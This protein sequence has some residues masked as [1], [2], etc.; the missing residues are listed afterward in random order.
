M[1]YL[2]YCNI[3]IGIFLLSG[4]AAPAAKV[5]REIEVENADI[6][7]NGGS[8]DEVKEHRLKLDDLMVELRSN[9][10]NK[11]F[12]L[13]LIQHLDR[14][15]RRSI[16]LSD[17]EFSKYADSFSSDEAKIAVDNFFEYQKISG[18][19]EIHSHINVKISD[20]L[21]FVANK[22]GRN[23]LTREEVIYVRSILFINRYMVYEMHTNGFNFNKFSSSYFFYKTLK[24]T[25]LDFGIH[26]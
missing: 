7:V 11:S 5:L 23:K 10:N 15:F 6:I 18:S 12:E 16:F 26:I 9:D 25:L 22:I 1:N 19:S 17:V 8:V 20:E 13:K 21:G 3:L 24:S 14:M 4:C 2:L